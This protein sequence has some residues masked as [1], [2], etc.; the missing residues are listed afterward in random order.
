M[1]ENVTIQTETENF[2]NSSSISV[3]LHRRI[4]YLPAKIPS[5]PFSNDFQ[6]ETLNPTTNSVHSVTACSGKKHNASEVSEYGLDPEL[7]FGITVGKIG[8]GLQNL[9]N[10]CFLNSVIQCLT[11]TEPLAAYLQSGKHKS[12]CHIAGF[13]ALCAIQNHVSRALQSTGRILSPQH[14]VGNLRCIS[15]NF[16]NAR[17]EDAH[18]YMVNLLESMHKCCLPSGVPSESSGAYEKSLVHKIFGGRLCSQVKCKHCNYSSNKFDPFLDLSLEIFKADS[19]QKALANFTAA[20]LLDGG[21]R[22]Y[23]CQKCKQ[24]V[25]A[26][27]QLTIHK[28]PY[29]LM[30]HLKRFFAHDPGLK[31]KKKVHFGCTLDLKPYVS[32]SYDGDVK[33]SL[34]G[35]LVHSGSSTHSGHYYCYVRTSNNMWYT[36]D[37]NR[38]SH[39]S[40]REVLNQ[41]AYMLFYVRDRKGIV[42]RKPVDIAK[43]E[44]MKLNVNANRDSSTSNQ[45][46]KEVTNGPMENKSCESCL[47]TEPQKNMSNVG[48]TRVPFMKDAIV[49]QKNNLI[50]PE[51]LVQSEKLVSGL[52]SQLQPQKGSQEGSSLSTVPANNPQ[53]STDKQITDGASQPQKVGS[54]ATGSACDE[55]GS[56]VFDSAVGCQTLVLH[57]SNLNEKHL[58]KSRKKFMKYNV[59]SIYFRST[60][61]FLAYLGSRKKNNRRSKRHQLG[62]KNPN[63]EKLDKH[64]FSSGGPSTS[65][66]AD[67]FPSASC[68]ESRTTKAG[69]RPDA[70]FKL[71]DKSLIENTAEGGFRKR[72]DMNCAVLAT[73]MRVE[74]ISGC[75]SGVN[76]FETRQADSLKDGKRDQMHNNLMSMLTRSLKETVVASWDAIELPQR[77]SLES[78]NDKN[79]SIGYVGDEWDEDYDKG[80]R[81]KLRGDK[82][83]FGGP[84]LFQEIAT[85]KC[86]SKRAKLDRSNSGNAPFRI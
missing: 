25:K 55:A 52:S 59:S 48:S 70:K 2:S 38:V 22:Q 51:S 36:L 73:A 39:V 64:A 29:V 50:L 12:S 16:R 49:Q 21:E 43:Q 68:F 5:K 82:Q 45:V 7:S 81:K 41:Q 86:R 35:V 44:N 54:S 18:E 33:Y 9:G 77:H 47:I 78:S 46:L 28:A 67:V 31:I 4:E 8:A 69:H 61:L 71:N 58:K 20:E 79:G 17:Q 19:L 37:D 14:L 65:G 15:R 66:K 74:N 24:K 75:G 83:S 84:N 6:L 53:T 3:S 23:Q 60:Y 57:K 42:P 76:Q 30:I 32:G 80:K 62:M 56:K 26:L 10:T 40:E 34:Y 72:V 85:E 27:K 11:Y 63:K 13:C 1:A